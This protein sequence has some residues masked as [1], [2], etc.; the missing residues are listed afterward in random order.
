MSDDVLDTPI[1]AEAAAKL[2]QQGLRFETLKPS[3]PAFYPWF[4]AMNRGFLSPEIDDKIID[5][6]VK[7][8][9]DRRIVGIWDD[10]AAAPETPVATSSAWITALTVPGCRTIPSWAISTVTVAPTHRRRGIARNLIEAELRTAAKLGVPAAI[11]TASEATIYER[12]GFAPSTQRADWTISTKRTGGWLGPVPDGRVHLVS[13]EQGLATHDV[14]ERA[15]LQNP[16]EI[17]LGGHLWERLFGVPGRGN[18]AELRVVRYDDA[19]GVAQGVAV[20]KL[21]DKPGHDATLHVEYLATATDDAYA[22]LWRYFIEHDLVAEVKAPLRST[23]EPVRW[24]LSDSRAAAEDDVH[25]HLWMRIL[26]VKR[27]LEARHYSAPGT[28]VLDLDDPLGYAHGNYLLA[29]DGEGVGT[30]TKLDSENGFDDN[31]RLALSVAM[32]GAIYLGG[33]SVSTL[34]HAGRIV[35]KEPGAAAAADAAFR[36]PTT[37]WLSTWF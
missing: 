9:H 2:A 32:L 35:E 37:P 24:Q 14:F 33:T 18:P 6:R 20:Y 13:R 12:F 31:H 7:D 11:L 17:E 34:V 21:E 26:D 28:F 25:D 23:N 3:D 27:T 8:L 5:D 22:A 4:R 10:T 19:E 1:D 15:K 16:G 36:S 29:I 30:V